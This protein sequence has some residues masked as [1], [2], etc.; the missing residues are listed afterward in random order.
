MAY[1]SLLQDRRRTLHARIVEAI[2]RLF[3]E[4]LNEQVERLAHHALR[5]EEWEKAFAYLRRAGAKAA[6]RLALREAEAYLEQA[7][8][9][10]ARLPRRRDLVEQSIDLR[11]ELRAVLFPLSEFERVRDHLS[12]AAILAGEVGDQAEART[13]RGPAG[14]LPLHHRG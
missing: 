2:E 10:V 5:G 9:V 6:D 11:V 13:V 7:A 12:Q 1:G 8:T 3:P 14:P 4:R